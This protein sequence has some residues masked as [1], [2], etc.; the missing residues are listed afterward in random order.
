MISLIKSLASS[1]FE[2]KSEVITGIISESQKRI[3]DKLI[4]TQ[5]TLIESPTP[6]KKTKARRLWIFSFFY[7]GDDFQPIYFYAFLF[8][9]WLNAFFALKFYLVFKGRSELTET[10]IITIFGYVISLI[11]VYN[12]F[13]GSKITPPDNN[14]P[15]G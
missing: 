14:T 15:E 9:M 5:N 2:K 7:S 12:K 4:S 11:A 8:S 3:E 1:L 6:K 13:K 10:F